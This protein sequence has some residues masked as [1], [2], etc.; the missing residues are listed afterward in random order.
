[1]NCSNL[2]FQGPKISTIAAAKAHWQHRKKRKGK[3]ENYAGSEN[4]SPFF[5]SGQGAALVPDN[6]KLLHQGSKK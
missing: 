2:R 5:D 1:L 6:V 4:H 3:G